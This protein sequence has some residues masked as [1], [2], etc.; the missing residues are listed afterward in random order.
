[1]QIVTVVAAIS[2][3][4]TYSGG[5]AFHVTDVLT[6]LKVELSGGIGKVANACVRAYPRCGGEARR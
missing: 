1:M 2:L 4:A 6:L 5:V 3:P